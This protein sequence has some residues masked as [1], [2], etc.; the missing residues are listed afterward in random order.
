MKKRGFAGSK[1]WW[2]LLWA[3]SFSSVTAQ[4]RFHFRHLSTGDGLSQGSVISMAQDD[5]GLL[6]FGT[7]D[8]LNIYDGK[9]FTVYRN[10]PKDSTTISNN[11]V[12]DV[13]VDDQGDLWIGTYNG[14]NR[15]CY[16]EG[17]FYQFFNSKN[18]PKSLANNSVWTLCQT[19]NG[20]LW[21]GTGGGVNVYKDGQFQRIVNNPNDPESLSKNYAVEVF[22]DSGGQIWVGTSNGLNRLISRGEDG[23]K[24]ERYYAEV[25]NPNALHN[26]FVQVINEDEQGNLWLGTRGGLHKYDQEAN[27]FTRF[28]HGE[29][30]ESTISHNDVRSLTFDQDGTLWVGTYNGLNKMS[31]EGEFT[32]ITNDPNIPHSLSKNTIKSTFMDRKGTLWVG[33]Y[34][35]GIN[36]LDE[37]NG[38]FTNYEH[39]PSGNGL[40]YDV[41]SSV[42]EGSNGQVYIGTEGGGINFLNP[43]TGKVS[44]LS[45]DN[46]GLSNNN[47]KA[48][49]LDHQDLWVGTL[50]R[51]ID[52]YNTRTGKFTTH[53]STQNGLVHNSVYAILREND[54]LMWIGTFGGGL[55]LFNQNTQQLRIFQH[56]INE[57]TGIS[58]NQVRLIC[59][60]GQGNLWVGTQYGLNLLHAEDISNGN[61]EF[62]R[63]FYDDQKKSGEDILVIYEDGQERIWVGTYESGLSLYDPMERKFVSYQLF[64]ASQGVSNVVHGIL[65]DEDHNLWVSS[66]HGITRVNL[67]DSSKLT[68]DQSDGLVS[69]EFNNNSSYKSSDGRMYFGGPQGLTAFYPQNIKT[70]HYAPNTVITDFKVYN[71]SVKVGAEDGILSKSIIETDRLTLDYD[72]AIFSIEFAIPNFINPDKNR[73]QYRL[74]GLE[75]HWNITSKTT[76]TYT[77]QRPGTYTFEVKGANNDGIW[78]DE[79]TSLQITVN[80]APWRT[81]WA[82][83]IYMV[84][85]IVSLYLLT[86]IILSRSRL[87]HQLE[88]EHLEHERQQSIHQMK[89]RFFTNISHEFRTPLTLI[90]GPL[91]QILQ[92]YR[93]SNKVY[94]QLKVMEKNSVRLLKLVNQLLDFRKFEN[95]HE[96]L[97]AGEGNVVKFVEEIFLSFKQYAKIHN[98]TYEL[99]KVDESIVVWYDRDKMERVF[100]NLISNAFKYTPES[101]EIRVK[102]WQEAGQMK[103]TI[104][105]TGIGLDQEHIDRIFDRF[106]EVQDT[107]ASPKHKHQKGTGIGLAIAR[108]VV[109]MHSGSIAVESKKGI[110]TTFTICLPQGDAHLTDDQRIRDF[111]DSEDLSTYHEINRPEME[112]SEKDQTQLAMADESLPCIL[113]VEDNDPVRKFIVD[114]FRDSYRVEEAANGMEGFK[115]AVQIVPDLV[116]SDVMMPKMDGIEFC[117]Q[118]KSNLKTSHIPFILLTARTSLIFKFEGLESGADEYINKPFN[119]KELKLKA[120]NLINTF[121]KMRDKFSDESIVKPAEITVSSID[122]KL[123]KRALAIV[124]ENISNEFFNIQLFSS[125]LGVS[126][127]M[128]FT[129]V[130]AWTNLTPNEFIHSM[131]MKRA[132]QILEQ[133]KVTIS[134]VSYQ[135]G[136]NNPKYFSKCFQKY[137][138]STPSEYAGKFS[139]VED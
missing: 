11:D 67:T 108:S 97:Q 35:G 7:R 120:R 92:E 24:F 57:P 65:E 38:N 137:H 66:N 89:L 79:I 109:E 132:A 48:L 88:L 106:Y 91:E 96:K 1:P 30:N 102:V 64:D 20:E 3:I 9:N 47:I 112:E 17:R 136:F 52:I 41:V 43:S 114:V 130:K 85:V 117:Y 46:S 84:I 16:S 126:R 13:L 115:K 100:Y 77:I 90:L 103:C 44:S 28:L 54:S 105:D 23:F 59:R 8:G 135:V 73:Y 63:Y 40:S 29:A 37:T 70:N 78:S 125:E 14:L 99:E 25:D 74:S 138:G 133:N 134:E 75:D 95:Q 22:Q 49:F 36:M 123:L 139:I 58:D 116:I 122:E 42:V 98:I 87:R 101:G 19:T 94:K 39:R 15:Y 131:R 69:N 21:V 27:R 12:L 71:Q 121:H 129:K 80:P 31:I 5:K 93:G 26:N 2:M 32:R 128:L 82:F 113:V 107:M 127:T 104:S 33:V 50:S 110:G 53:Y 86:S 34:Y 124:E 76:A 18:D 60:D 72:Q 61:Y 4:Q 10:D 111:K 51:G 119:V 55:H 62:E 118:A 83:V 81:W 45:T 56:D 6:W 68:F